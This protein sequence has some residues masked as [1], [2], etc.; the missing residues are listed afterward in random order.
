[1]LEIDLNKLIIVIIGVKY[2][3]FWYLKIYVLLI[4]YVYNVKWYFIVESKDWKIIFIN[5]NF[6][7]KI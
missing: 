4:I 6:M 1:M 2:F 5:F 3:S 7:N